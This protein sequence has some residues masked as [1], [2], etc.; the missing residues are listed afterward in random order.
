MIR[1][2]RESSQGLNEVRS[3]H[4][5]HLEVSLV[6]LRFEPEL[7]QQNISGINVSLQGE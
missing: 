5:G 3:G 6:D 1:E 4:K 2:T 7:G